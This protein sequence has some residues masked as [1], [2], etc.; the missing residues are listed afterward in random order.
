[1]SLASIDIDSLDHDG[2]I[3]HLHQCRTNMGE[4]MIRHHMFTNVSTIPLGLF[5]M[6]ALEWTGLDID[7]LYSLLDGASPVSTGATPE[8]VSVVEAIRN[9]PAAVKLLSS[10]RDASSLLTE[11]RDLGG[12]VGKA[13]TR[14]LLMDGHRS[15]SGFDLQNQCAIELP[16]ML[17][18]RILSAVENGIED[19]STEALEA[20]AFIRQ[21]V[22]E[23]HRQV[24][25]EE[26]ADAR[27][28]FRLKDERGIYND[29]WATGITRLA[30]LAAGRKLV[31]DKT[32]SESEHL[33]EATWG[34]IQSLL[35][36]IIEVTDDELAERGAIR[37]SRT[38]RDA[39]PSLG[40]P[41]TPPAPVTGL[42][43]EVERMNRASVVMRTAMT[44]TPATGE[45]TDL[46]GTVASK[47]LHEGRARIAVGNY[48]L[49]QISPG[50]V[51]VTST[52]SEAFNAVAGQVG[53][54]VADT[55]GI[56]SHLSIVS[57]ELGIPCIVA[58]KNATTSLKEG[59][60][61]RVD[62]NTGVVTVLND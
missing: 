3:E 54:I 47:G 37:M 43:W 4:M 19:R 61:I 31:R 10:G 17:I 26:L 15:T 28:L 24:F 16:G 60:L 39:P 32:L 9:D 44:S 27:N 2:L 36:G 49:S 20:A 8:F 13:V 18:A 51:L 59:S 25:D 33:I 21:R 57:R 34:E 62:A 46:T 6:D 38:W 56:L 14:F 29:I 35:R 40:P 5:L 1:M 41:P 52:H 30:I 45:S 23:E 55:G 53:A 50:D 48:D 22:P 58:C 7:S 12:A 42:P 11:L